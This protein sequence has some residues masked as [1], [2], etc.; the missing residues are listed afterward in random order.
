[1]NPDQDKPKEPIAPIQPIFNVKPKAPAQNPD[2]TSI[3]AQANRLAA[4][5]EGSV[6]TDTVLSICKG[7]ESVKFR[8][9]NGHVFYRY[10][11]KLRTCIK[12][13]TSR[14]LSASTAASMSASSDEEALDA[15]HQFGSWCPKCEE[16]YSAAKAFAKES[17]Y[18]LEGKLFSK[19]LS[20]K[21]PE[22]KHSV[23]LPYSYS[24]QRI[25]II[26]QCQECKREHKEALKQKLR[27]EEEQQRK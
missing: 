7:Q 27:Q 21:C 15:A 26:S 22:R 20:L 4:L 6:L 16:F 11:D 10:V 17:G 13:A 12:T 1:L 18:K 9:Q 24:K 23:P 25:N 3:L 14:K 5:F 8:C 2:F 19:H